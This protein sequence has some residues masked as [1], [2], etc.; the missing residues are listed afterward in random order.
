MLVIKKKLIKIMVSLFTTSWLKVESTQ[1]ISTE[2]LK[3]G[4]YQ[5]V[6]DLSIVALEWVEWS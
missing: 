1:I 4:D 2:T 6:H 5:L 3:P